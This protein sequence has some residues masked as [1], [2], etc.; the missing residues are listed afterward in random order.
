ME[1]YNWNS[2]KWVYQSFLGILAVVA[3]YR[4]LDYYYYTMKLSD[5]GDLSQKILV[6]PGTPQALERKLSVMQTDQLER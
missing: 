2:L 6:W 4:E 5:A 1:E 3:K